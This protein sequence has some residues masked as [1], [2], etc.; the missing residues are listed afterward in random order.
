MQYEEQLRVL[1]FTYH[2]S[3]ID[4]IEGT[5]MIAVYNFLLTQYDIDYSYFF[6]FH[7]FSISEVSYSN[8]FQEQMSGNNIFLQEE[9]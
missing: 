2:H 7:P 8:I 9:L 6:T 1:Y 3:I 4:A 5:C